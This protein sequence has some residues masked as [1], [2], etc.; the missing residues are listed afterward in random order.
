VERLQHFVWLGSLVGAV[1]CALLFQYLGFPLAWVLAFVFY[2]LSG[3]YW[4][5]G[6]EI[7]RRQEITH[8]AKR[9][10]IHFLA[11]IGGPFL[12]LLLHIYDFLRYG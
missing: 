8:F 10:W 11:A 6:V 2:L 5:S 3:L 7:Y 9:W 12:L 4:A 1:L